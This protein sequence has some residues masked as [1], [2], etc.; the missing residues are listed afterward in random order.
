MDRRKFLT[1][2]GALALTG[3]SRTP[4]LEHRRR[5]NWRMATSW[6]AGMPILQDGAELF[7]R[8]VADLTNGQFNIEVF[9]A[10]ELMSGFA[11]FEAASRGDIDCFHSSSYYWAEKA[12][13]CQWFS[14]VPF[15]LNTQGCLSWLFSGNGMK[16]WADL[17]R[18]HNLI[19]YPMGTTGSQMGGWF[20]D[21]VETLAD[22]AN[23]RIRI[24]RL[25][26]RVYS[27]LGATVF[28]LPLSKIYTAMKDGTINAADWVGPHLDKRMGLDNLAPYYYYP[29][30]HEPSGILE[31][32]INAASFTQLPPDLQAVVK[33][34]AQWVTQYM[35]AELSAKN[36][37]A[38]YEIQSGGTVEVLSFPR[39]IIEVFHRTAEQVLEA[40]AGKDVMA[41]TINEDYKRF[42]ARWVDW[43]MVESVGYFDMMR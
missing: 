9:A 31:L 2:A 30:W 24:P 22:I 10:D 42:L 11:V 13:G 14:S 34:A 3:C 12:P 37:E 28:S 20:K 41:R 19:P 8:K 26:G 43:G 25:A 6:P 4:E 40:E 16:L 35:I 27:R 23:L 17:Y 5:V 1:G 33:A 36:A 29:G 39:E 7:A 38:L 15:G 32:G 18:K 21:K